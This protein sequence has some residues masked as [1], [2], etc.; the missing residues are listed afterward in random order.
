T[1]I[2]PE[3]EIDIEIWGP[4]GDIGGP[5]STSFVKEP[6]IEPTDWIA[7]PKVKGSDE[8]SRFAPYLLD[9]ARVPEVGADSAS[10]A[11]STSEWQ[12]HTA[13]DWSG[14]ACAFTTIESEHDQVRI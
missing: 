14:V 2:A 12:R 11:Q 13:S 5:R 9:P 6:P 10:A 4:S 1:P 8:W 3:E 7:L